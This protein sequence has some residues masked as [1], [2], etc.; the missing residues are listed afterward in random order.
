MRE[1]VQSWRREERG[2]GSAGEEEVQERG[3]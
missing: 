1:E 3:K 2:E